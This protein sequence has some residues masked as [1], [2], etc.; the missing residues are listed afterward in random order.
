MS[1]MMS[2]AVPSRASAARSWL[3]ASGSSVTRTFPRN[4]SIT[5]SLSGSAQILTMCGAQA[6]RGAAVG[7]IKDPEVDLTTSVDVSD[8]PDGRVGSGTLG[9]NGLPAFHE[10]LPDPVH[11]RQEQEGERTC[12]K[13]AGDDHHRQRTLRLAADSMRE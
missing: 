13:S 4:T 2:N 9:G 12:G 5:L 10:P 7:S 11:H 3:S 1:A 8:R 6:D